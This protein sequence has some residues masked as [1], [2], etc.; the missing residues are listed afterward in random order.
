MSNGK[1]QISESANQ[2][3]GK[4]ANACTLDWPSGPAALAL[5]QARARKRKCQQIG[6]SVN[7]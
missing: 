4:S 6:E 3:I 1:W 7:Q 5:R 2:R